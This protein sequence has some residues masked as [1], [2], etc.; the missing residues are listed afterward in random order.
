M[1]RLHWGI[2]I[3]ATSVVPFSGGPVSPQNHTG[4]GSLASRAK[5]E[6]NVQPLA[7]NDQNAHLRFV[8]VNRE[9]LDKR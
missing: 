6:G 3:P 4:V 7:Q 1:S 8:N 2:E 9:Y 5:G